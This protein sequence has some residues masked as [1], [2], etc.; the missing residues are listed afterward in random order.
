M[1]TRRWD[2]EATI[3]A[4]GQEGTSYIV[5]IN[6]EIHTRNRRFLRKLTG[7]E[8]LR[9]PKAT[10]GAENTTTTT[11]RGSGHV[12]STMES[13]GDRR[14]KGILSDELT[15]ADKLAWFAAF[16]AFVEDNELEQN[17]R[18][19]GQTH[20]RFL[21]EVISPSL[22]E[23]LQRD[24]TKQKLMGDRGLLSRLRTCVLSVNTR[25]Y[26]F[27]TKKQHAGEQC[28]LWWEKKATM[29]ELCKLDTVSN[30]DILTLQLIEGVYDANLRRALL[31][32]IDDDLDDLVE[33]ASTWSD[34]NKHT[35]VVDGDAD[36]E[37]LVAW[38]TTAQATLHRAQEWYTT[39]QRVAGSQDNTGD[40]KC[41][42]CGRWNMGAHLLEGCPAARDVCFIC[43]SKGHWANWCMSR[44]PRK[45]PKRPRMPLRRIQLRRSNTLPRQRT[46]EQ[47][48][49]ETEEDV[50]G[51]THSK[52]KRRER[53]RPRDPEP[54]EKQEIQNVKPEAKAVEE[55]PKVTTGETH[56]T[57][58]KSG[59]TCCIMKITATAM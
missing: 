38:R 17:D 37:K 18:E 30:H 19:G 48:R 9:P 56:L 45:T 1:K 39:Y 20:V 27:Q 13:K 32:R 2:E 40:T 43:G 11:P 46:H 24:D 22:T 42:R 49:E 29:A 10:E 41:T 53:S 57:P 47:R 31:N 50:P 7:T 5:E 35:L 4:E 23:I 52:P 54:E 34:T 16:E 36:T 55:T 8:S 21:F 15:N 59:V 44:H 51:Q 14:P 12:Q 3:I 26:E 33:L 6:E 28:T 25:R 58:K